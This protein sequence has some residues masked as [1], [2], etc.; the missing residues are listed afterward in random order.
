MGAITQGPPIM[1]ILLEVTFITLMLCMCVGTV[2][3]LMMV[4]NE[5]P[6]G[7]LVRLLHILL[8]ALLICSVGAVQLWKYLGIL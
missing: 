3:T 6:G 7:I 8:V 1:H 2:I 5:L 4:L